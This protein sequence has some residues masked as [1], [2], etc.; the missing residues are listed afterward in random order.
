MKLSPYTNYAA[1]PCCDKQAPRVRP[2]QLSCFM[3]QRVPG[4]WQPFE[5]E[6]YYCGNCGQAF[7]YMKARGR[8]RKRLARRHNAKH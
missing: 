8:A 2:A 7:G 1:C 3:M 6:F 4:R 5:F